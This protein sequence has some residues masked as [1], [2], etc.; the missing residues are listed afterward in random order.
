[1]DTFPSRTHFQ[2]KEPLQID[3]FV[4]YNFLRS[5]IFEMRVC[6][7]FLTI[8]IDCFL[9]GYFAGH[10]CINHVIGC[11]GKNCREMSG[12]KDGYTTPLIHYCI[13]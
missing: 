7:G 4:F 12:K 5:I 3:N 1:M 2:L 6:Y 13:G 9:G 11:F 8:E 10:L